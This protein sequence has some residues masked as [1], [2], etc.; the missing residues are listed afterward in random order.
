MTPIASPLDSRDILAMIFDHLAPGLMDLKDSE[1]LSILSKTYRKALASLARTC[2]S[3]SHHALDFLWQEL[4]DI[5]PLLKVLPEYKCVES[6]FMLCGAIL[7]EH[8]TR[9]QLYAVRVHTV[10]THPPLTEDIHP[11]VWTF[12]A[13]GCRGIP[14]MPHLHQLAAYGLS[15]SDTSPLA[16]LLSPALRELDI[17]F[18]LEDKGEDRSRTPH[19][20]TSLLQTLPLLA[21]KL[22]H[23]DVGADFNL[24]QRSLQSFEHFTR[25][26]YLSMPSDLALNEHMLQVLSSVPTLQNLS[27]RIDLS[28]IPAPAFGPHAFQQ[29]TR[30]AVSGYSDHLVAFILAC[31]FPN[32]VRID[33]RIRQPPSAGQPRDV[34]TALCQRC[35][36]TLLTSFEANLTHG[37]ASRPSTLMEY[38]EP[39]LALPNITSFHVV[40]FLTDPSIRDD[41]LA[42]FGAAWPRLASFRIEHHTRQYSNDNLARF[43]AAWPR[44]AS[45]RVQH[46]TGQY[47]D[48]RACPTLSGIL[49][50]AQ[51]CPGLTTFH[52][53]ELDPRGTISERGAVPPLGHGLRSIS[54]DN[55][56]P[57]LSFQVY[58]EVA[59]VLDR[60]FPSLE[61]EDWRPLEVRV[62]GK[63]WPDVLRLMKVM[64]VGR[65]NGRV[66]ADLQRQG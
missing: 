53:P 37:F 5:Q 64:R 38:F 31:R 1:E 41:D 32:L 33:L 19:I 39:L 45:F 11:S 49:E 24:G 48:V 18:E 44:L 57:P 21:P 25:L 14:L 15:S 65:E 55:V 47:S 42:R 27:C 52:I 63:G 66:Y 20:S 13:A 50:L 2:R 36:P 12:L 61:L 58:M 34:F 4:D 26:K 54:V 62:H 10:V 60:A 23:L 16:L 51:R 28:G 3:V 40:F 30:L 35:N 17:S 7:P 9:F 29:L 56:T 59:T 8:W 43:S 6:Q 46:H 22:E